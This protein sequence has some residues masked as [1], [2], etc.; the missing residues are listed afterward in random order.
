MS[1]HHNLFDSQFGRMINQTS[2]SPRRS[3][4][5]NKKHNLPKFVPKLQPGVP[6]SPKSFNTGMMLELADIDSY[7]DKVFKAAKTPTIEK[8]RNNEMTDLNHTC[9]SQAILPELEDLKISQQS[10]SKFKFDES[11]I[12]RIQREKH[13]RSSNRIGETKSNNA[14]QKN[15]SSYSNFPTLSMFE[16]LEAGL[17]RNCG[18]KLISGQT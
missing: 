11:H 3:T 9:K 8:M 1:P 12:K 13:D 17:C 5:A 14:D 16:R 6:A 15:F 10:S 7:V 18:S 2:L 4:I